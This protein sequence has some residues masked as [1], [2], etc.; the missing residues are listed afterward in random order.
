MLKTFI[1]YYRKHIK[2]VIFVILGSVAVSILELLF[3]M[4]VRNLLNNSV[5]QF[6]MQELKIWSAVLLILYIA[7]YFINYALQ[8]YGHIMG[9]KIESE[10]RKN[11]FRH[12]QSM[13]YRFFDNN[14]TGQLITRLTGDVSEVSELAFRG[15]SDVIVCIISMLG[16]IGMLFYLNWQLGFVIGMLLIIKGVH[17][18]YVNVKMKESFRAFRA[19][20]GDVTAKAE[21]SLS[22]IRLTKAFARE[23]DE[24]QAFVSVSNEYEKIK[25]GSFKIIAH[26]M[27]SMSFFTNITNLAVMF[28]GGYLV[29]N[30]E[31]LL[32]DLVAFFL[33]VNIFI[34]PLMRLIAFSEIYQRGMAGCYRLYE[35]FLEKPDFT[36]QTQAVLCKNPRGKIEF[37]NV[38]FGY[39][40]ENIVLRNFNLVI[41][42]GET[43]AFVG[44]TGAGKTTIVN[45]LLR[46]YEPLAGKIFFDGVDIKTI[47]QES[48]RNNIGL[49]QQDVFLFSESVKFN[50]AYGD[51]TA[52][53][54]SIKM[55]AQA[56]SADSF[57]EKLTNGYDT[58][59]GERGVKLS[60]GQKQRIAIARVFLKNP[61][62]VILDEAT[63]A[64][65]SRTEKQIQDALD[66][67]IEG[68]TTIIIA[69]RLSTVKKADKIV[70]LKNGSVIEFGSHAELL[71]K[72][73]AYYELYYAD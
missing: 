28:Y 24:Y 67:L 2:T 71:S 3:P 54:S 9:I 22:G 8:Y 36:D 13:T 59:I 34:K 48:L 14:K 31:M 30:R 41:N 33:Y 63:S 17:T 42:P 44:E 64:L 29:I 40:K 61:P 68:R 6:N 26:F 70:V 11:L 12:I 39:S 50:I 20:T 38:D 47:Q 16:T 60:G 51:K 19:K 10:M 69:H 5:P 53:F 32:S 43:V 73:G 37:C 18:V 35:L 57:I 72:K 58:E 7:M 62:V 65:D 4:I 46:F 45:L 55:A 52:D 49:V 23:S 27:S 1:G 66:K 56:A 21:E 15:P 25:I